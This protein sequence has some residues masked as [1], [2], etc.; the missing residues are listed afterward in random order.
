MAA[1]IFCKNNALNALYVLHIFT[2]E[3]NFPHLMYNSKITKK[4]TEYKYNFL[5]H[6]SI[7]VELNF[8]LTDC[9]RLILC[10]VSNIINYVHPETLFCN[11]NAS[12]RR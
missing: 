9:Y 4:N 12:R 6:I 5:W 8:I 3:I 2:R 1:L 7:P 11:S 10:I